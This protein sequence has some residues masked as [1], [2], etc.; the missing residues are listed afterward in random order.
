MTHQLEADGI[1]LAFDERR[2]LSDIY[3]KCETGII[4]GLLGR[5]G[6]GKSCL[7]KIIYGTMPCNKSV[8]VDKASLPKAYQR[9]DVV[10]FLPQFHFIPNF[11]SIKRIFN[12]FELDYAPFVQLFPEF[13]SHYQLKTGHLSGGERRLLEVYIILKSASKFTLLDEPFSQLSPL[14]IEKIQHLLQDEKK[15]KGLLITDHLYQQVLDIS[16]QLYV[17]ANGKTH[18]V[19]HMDEI[20][21]LGY[22]RH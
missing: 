9:P 11:L 7:M 15:N 20:E 4:T 3:L 14:Q 22:V 5:N 6:Q 8:R 1:Q 16:D 2:I 13:A 18:L 17:L 21:K 19:K 10:S 12:D